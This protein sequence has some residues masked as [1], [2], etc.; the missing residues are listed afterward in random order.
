MKNKKAQIPIVI[1]VLGVFAICSL[2]IISFIVSDVQIFKK[3]FGV[4]LIESVHADVEKFYLYQNLGDSPSV[5]SEKVDARIEGDFLVF[6]RQIQNKNFVFGETN[7]L[8]KLSY[9]LKFN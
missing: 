6:E 7:D 2:A 1:L 4:N 3:D 9:K 5:A 8:I